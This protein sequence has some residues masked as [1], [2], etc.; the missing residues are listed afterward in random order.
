MSIK[1]SREEKGLTQ[2]QVAKKLK[3]SKTTV[4]LW[5]A[6]IMKPN[7]KNMKKLEEKL[8]IVWEEEEDEDED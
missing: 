3:A 8:G 5:D 1:K 2:I 4:Q 6:G 7:E